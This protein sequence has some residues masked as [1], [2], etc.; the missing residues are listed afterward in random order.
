MKKGTLLFVF[1]LILQNTFSAPKL[2]IGIV[3]DQMR[4]DYLFAYW[5]KFGNNGFKKLLRDGFLCKNTNFNYVPTYTGPGH[6]SIYTGTTPSMHGIIGNDWFD[7]KEDAMVYCTEDAQVTGTGTTN[8][9]GKMSPH[10]MLT[11]TVG[12]ELRVASN[13][14]SKVFGISLKDRSAILPAGHAANGAFWFDGVSGDFITSS[15]YM[16]ALPAWLDKFNAKKLAAQYLSQP[17]KTLLPIEQYTES[18]AD[19]NP[20]EKP[21]PAEAKPVFPHDLP[22]ILKAIEGNYGLIKITPYGNSI[23]TDLT[24]AIIEGE[25]LGKDEFTDLLCVS[26]SAP[27]YIGHQFAPKSIE[28]EDCYLRLDKD[29]ENLLLYLEKNIG[30]NNF[31]I[32]LTADHAA[33]DNPSYLESMN[34]PSGYLAIDSYINELN[35]HLLERFPLNDPSKRF[36]RSIVNEQIYLNRTFLVEQ[37]IDRELMEKLAAEFF[38]RIEGVAGVLTSTQLMNQEYT[39]GIKHLLQN[40]FNEI[41]SG[42]VIVSLQPSWMDHEK[43]GTTHGS[44]YSYDTHVPLI[45]YGAGITKGSTAEYIPITSIA[46]TLSLM[47]NIPY[48]N[49]NSGQPI[50]VLVK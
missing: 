42:D 14:R 30:K 43:Q 2:V 11:T 35:N 29:I 20:Y 15:Y 19:D 45:W 38:R 39:T 17:W 33:A 24:K 27:D 34:I 44:P 8:A 32:F 40:G 25:Q 47:L 10:R 41:R 49:G 50:E 23:T 3:V 1:F 4:Y 7:R 21:F 36:V 46:P 5:N 48:T 28:T 26:Y 37:K 18:I 16:P 13:K 22:A 31:M 9:T 12:D 6:A